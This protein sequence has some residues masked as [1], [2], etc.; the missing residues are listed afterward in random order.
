MQRSKLYLNAK[1]SKLATQLLRVLMLNGVH[2]EAPRAFQVERTVI[3]EETFFGRALGDF[4]SDAID[5]FLRLPGAK[6]TGT[7]KNEEVSPQIEGLNAELVE[8]ERLV[9]DGADE[10]LSGARDLIENGARIREFLGLRKHEGSELLARE[11]ALA[12]EQG[13]V[14]ILIQSDLAGVEGRKRKIVAV[15]KFLPIEVEGCGGFF[16]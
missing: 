6:V 5:R 15:L 12:I 11:A 1:F 4:Q 7:K 16:S 8:F 10:I 9:V 14:E 2:P 3:D 13:A